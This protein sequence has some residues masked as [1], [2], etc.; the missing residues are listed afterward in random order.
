MGV[1]T[2]SRNGLITAID[3][4]TSKVA[5]FVARARDDGRAEI[6]GIAHQLSRGLRNGNIVDMEAAELSI[7][8]AVEAAEQMAGENVR[9][10][11]I[12]IANGAPESKLVTFEVEIAGHEI[13]HGDLRRALDPA[14]LHAQQADDR[15]AIHTIPVA[16]SIDGNRGVRDPRGMY[17]EKLGVNMHLVTAAAGAVRNLTSCVSRCHLEIEHIVAAP[18]ASGLACLVEDEMSLGAV[19]IDMGGGTTTISVFFDG[20]VVFVDAIPIGGKHVTNDIARGLSCALGNAERVK[21]LY[22]SALPSPSDDDEFIKV[23]LVGEEESEV[24]QIPR[25]ML[26][27]IVR[28][29]LEEIFEMARAS[30]EHA[31]FDKIAG[32]RVVLTGGAS[33]LTGARELAARMLDKQ[34]RMG[35]PAEI[36]GLA[37]ATGGPAFATCA[38]LVQYALNHRSETENHVFRAIQEPAG[39]FGRLGNWIR[40]NL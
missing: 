23:P 11:A 21:T 7:R 1:K 34:V 36:A 17:G 22:G 20:E 2:K 8:S 12:S 37:E 18:F 35:R 10:A 19:C 24:A 28:P 6:V 29:R 4:G 13:S 14:W 25:S 38:G 26:V 3:L 15:R 30:L 9:A 5:C 31:G 16:Y 33:Q 39:R 32:R 27:G 40:E